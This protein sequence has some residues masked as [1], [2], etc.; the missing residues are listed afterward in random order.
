VRRRGQRGFSLLEVLSAISLFALVAAAV[1]SLTTS[2]MRQTVWNRHATA[3]AMV[4]QDEVE[5][6]RGLAYETLESRNRVVTIDGQDFS[7]TTTV[8][9]DDPAAGMSRIQVRVDWTGPEGSRNYD[10]ETIF[11]DIT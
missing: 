1:A 10:V 3:A 4:A 11:T 6:L 7:V 2:A 9:E 5:N 8:L